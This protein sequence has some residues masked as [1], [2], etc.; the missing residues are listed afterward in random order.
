M[1]KILSLLF[2]ALLAMSAWADTV[3]TV[4][5]S[6][7]NFSDQQQIHELNIDGVILAFDKGTNTNNPPKYYNT[8]A[9]IRLYGGNSMKVVA[10]QNIKKI[11]F[12]F[13]EGDG[14]N[15]TSNNILCD[16]GSYN[17]AG[18]QWTIGSSDPS[19]QVMF[20]IEGT[21]G[22]RRVH[23]LVI[24]IEDANPV[25]ELV[26]PVFHPEDGTTFTNSL[27]VTITCATQN[28]E[29]QYY[30]VIDGEIDY[31]TYHYYTGPFFIN[32]TKTF[33]AW[34]SR[35]NESTD[36]VYATYTKVEQ[37]V[38]APVF[39]PA[40]CSFYNSIIVKLACATPG[41]V[42]YY[43]L[44]NELWSEYVD[45][46]PVTTDLT[47]WAKAMVGDVESEVV[48]ATYTKLP[49]TTV[50]VTFDATV[51]KGNGGLDAHEYTVVKEPVTMYV[52]NGA[53]YDDHYRIYAGVEYYF[54]STGAPIIS[55]QFNGM[56]SNTASNLSLAEG[57]TG[58]WTTSGTDGLWEGCA[59]RVEFNVNKQA[60]F[61]TIIVTL[62]GPTTMRGDVNGN[63]IVDM[64]DLTALI[65]Y[66]LDDS[67]SI[68]FENTAI[69][70]SL[71]SNIVDMDDLTA[72]INYLLTNEWPD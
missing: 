60:R 29:I 34:A 13:G 12:T 68:N 36:Y 23:Q 63:S 8:G 10:E 69:C 11:D 49:P 1:K 6:Q 7:Q 70:N 31:T 61:T 42:I 43:S 16:V 46:I 67:T 47:I 37:T 41:A 56:S 62:A 39:D 64:D 71:D 52:G 18:K 35:G 24:T 30:E 2:V 3:V 25:T 54:E 45:P 5:F 44:D 22:H 38:E 21:S 48:S 26:D 14:G 9:S 57:T 32:E 27:E 51:D 19:K 66:L 17:M 33:A 59:Q 50:D 58:T 72:L 40:S 55:I 28:A 15:N 4:D 20:T 65:N 53:V